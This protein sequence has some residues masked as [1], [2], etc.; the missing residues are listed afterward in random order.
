M[1]EHISVVR[2]MSE[3]NVCITLFEQ[4]VKGIIPLWVWAKPTK[5]RCQAPPKGG[6]PIKSK[7]CLRYY[8]AKAVSSHKI[9]QKG[10]KLQWQFVT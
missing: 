1:S 2:T 7:L 10:E 6:E 4:K 9:T 5:T 3:N 8:T